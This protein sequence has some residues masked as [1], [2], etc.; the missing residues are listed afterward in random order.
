MSIVTLTKHT[1]DIDQ[2]R[3]PDGGAGAPEVTEAMVEAGMA[4]LRTQ[5]FELWESRTVEKLTGLVTAVYEAMAAASK[6][7]DF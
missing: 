5:E 3:A 2:S 1:Q 4:A 7:R 6:N